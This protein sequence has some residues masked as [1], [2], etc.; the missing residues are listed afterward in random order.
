MLLLLL[1][2]LSNLPPRVHARMIRVLG[3]Q[4]ADGTCARVWGDVPEIT[5]AVVAVNISSETGGPG[6]AGAA[7]PRGALMTLQVV[8][9]DKLGPGSGPP[10]PGDGGGSSADALGKI[11][12]R[13][14]VPGHGDSPWPWLWPHV[15]AGSAEWL[16]DDGSRVARM[17]PLVVAPAAGG[18]W[19]GGGPAAPTLLE[20]LDCA[21]E[22]RALSTLLEVHHSAGGEVEGW[23]MWGEGGGELV[24]R[25]LG[26]GDASSSL[27]GRDERAVD[28][29]GWRMPAPWEGCRREEGCRSV[30]ER[31]VGERSGEMRRERRGGGRR[32]SVG[33][34]LV[35]ELWE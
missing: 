25:L 7:R 10:G 4:D 12:A 16:M 15:P 31:S 24:A 11:R 17:R 28:S 34:T 30:G 20:V 23:G 27:S 22:V 13:A 14:Q 2:H 3:G 35:R 19:A 5:G 32:S 6:N 33:G 1:P 29:V 21:G 26:G 9:G 18:P 8:A